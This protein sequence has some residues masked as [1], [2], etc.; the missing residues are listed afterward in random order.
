MRL[1]LT[2]SIRGNGGAPAT[3]ELEIEAAA[4]STSG[5]LARALSTNLG[6]GGE[7]LSSGGRPV[8]SSTLVGAAP[9]VDGAALTLGTARLGGPQRRPPRSPVRLAVAHGP[10]AGRTLE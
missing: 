7:A 8:P 9:L 1:R 6:L 2:V 3:H 10:D 4:G 5:E